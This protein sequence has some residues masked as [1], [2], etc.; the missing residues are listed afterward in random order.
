MRPHTPPTS[1]TS[2]TRVRVAVR[3]TTPRVPFRSGTYSA[4]LEDEGTG[5]YLVLART[6]RHHTWAQAACAALKIAA[7]RGYFVTNRELVERR[8]ATAAP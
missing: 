7:R 8:I 2:V 3:S 1:M 4:A 5:D 6:Q